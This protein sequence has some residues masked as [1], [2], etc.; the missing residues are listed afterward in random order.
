MEGTG[1]FWL[2][3]SMIADKLNP[4]GGIQD[5]ELQHAATESV[6]GGKLGGS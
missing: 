6:Y 3:R 5:L 2:I 1:K 4:P